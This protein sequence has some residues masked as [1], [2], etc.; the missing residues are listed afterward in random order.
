MKPSWKACL[1]VG[2]SVFVLY[3]CIHYWSTVAGLAVSLLGAAMPLLIGAALAYA[4]N[5][6]MT[7][8]ERHYFPRTQKKW[9]IR[10]RR[11]VCMTL[12]L[13]SVAAVIL[14]VIGLIVP[15]LVSC[16]AVIINETPGVI[17]K[18]LGYLEQWEILPGDI[19]SAL[20]AID[21]QSK[22][23]EIAGVLTSGIGSVMDILLKTVTS[24]F[25][26]LTTA[27]IAVIFAIYILGGKEMLGRQIRKL[28][29][30]YLPRK[31]K[32]GLWDLG[33]VLNDCFHSYLVGQ[34]TEAVILGLLCTVGM[35]IL[36]LP[37]AAMV[38]ALVAFTALIPVAGA[39]IGAGVGA[40]MI[41]TVSP[42]KALIFLVFIVI[43][44]QLEGNIIYPKVVG[45]S[46]GLP[47]I[48]V[49]A[50][51]TVGGGLMGVLGMLLGVPVAAAIY[52]L[53]RRDINRE[54]VSAAQQE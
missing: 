4:V 41:L 2:V 54:T 21:W 16:V 51:V 46:I 50:A 34:C 1:R 6:P 33:G 9:L 14:L 44:Q 37:Y 52:R 22:L 10:S 43:L 20:S 29:D 35:F 40:F 38:G 53:L 45:K 39:Y 12:A 15:Q 13:L 28:A 25:S 36:Q 32:D 31:Y 49:L 47:G 27:L 48:W 7:V 23:G 18:A 30:R 19:L 26:W 42:V 11:P 3:L 5:I 24:V 8:Y 17:R